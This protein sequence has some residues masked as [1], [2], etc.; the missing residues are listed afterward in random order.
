MLLAAVILMVSLLA[1]C[2]S[3]QKARGNMGTLK[4]SLE[5]SQIFQT[6]QVLPEYRYFFHGSV[7]KPNAIMGI[8]RNYTLVTRLWKEA[9]DLTSEQLK[10]WVDR[11]L[12]YLPPVRTFG[13]YILGPDGEQVGI[14]YS[15]YPDAPVSVQPD[16]R[17]EIIPQTSYPKAGRQ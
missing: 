9:P 5:V 11:I 16:K 17:I 6:Y 4:L 3:N 13:A 10:R 14:W 15:P 8:D 2:A 7:N 12:G 1:G